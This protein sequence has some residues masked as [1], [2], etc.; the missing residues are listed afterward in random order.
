MFSVYEGDHL[1]MLN[2]YNAFIRVSYNI[3]PRESRMSIYSICS[4]QYNKSSRWCG[5]N[6]L[7]YKAL[8][9][10]VSIR[11]QLKRLLQRFKVKLISC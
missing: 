5:E 2:V 10:A 3:S 6:F 8:S 7:S 9:H 4:P 1:T 11:E